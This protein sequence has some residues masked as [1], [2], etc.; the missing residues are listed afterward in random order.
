MADQQQTD[1]QQQY[2]QQQQQQQQLLQQQQQ[3]PPPPG[4]YLYPSPYQPPAYY[5]GQQPPPYPYAPYPPYGYPPP[6]FYPGQQPPPQQQRPLGKSNKILWIGSLHQDTTEDEL[7]QAFGAFGQI[8]SVKLV[9]TKACGFVTFVEPHCAL[10]AHEK[11]SQHKFHNQDIKIGWGKA[12]QAG[13]QANQPRT[14]YSQQDGSLQQNLPDINR[15]L[16]PQP[17][18]RTLWIG[19]V[20][21]VVNETMLR[22]FFARFGTIEYVRLWVSRHCAFITFATEQEATNAKIGMD[23]QRIGDTIVRVNYGKQ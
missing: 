11:M 1:I 16:P 22:Q 6:A 4:S 12:D 19:N 21:Q 15:D 18:S 3:Q 23:R 17:V 10:D 7:S 14:D 5:P 8:E 9:R 2:L 20:T 13:Y